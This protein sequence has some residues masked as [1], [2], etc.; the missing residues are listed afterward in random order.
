MAILFVERGFQIYD[1]ANEVNQRLLQPTH[2]IKTMIST[3][4]T[5][6]WSDTQTL[7]ISICYKTYN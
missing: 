1:L 5:K 3:I 4:N 7:A 2:T 6:L